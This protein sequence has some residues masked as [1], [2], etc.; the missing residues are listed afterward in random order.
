MAGKNKNL[1]KSKN[2][3]NPQFTYKIFFP[4]SP[5]PT[6]HTTKMFLRVILHSR[7]VK[8]TR[9]FTL[10]KSQNGPSKSFGPEYY[11]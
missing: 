5:T 10:Q 3:K 9:D 1:K 7:A 2:S 11:I 8:K 4:I 6:N